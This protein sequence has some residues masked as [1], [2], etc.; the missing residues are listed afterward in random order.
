MKDVT[1]SSNISRINLHTW[2]LSVK[3]AT[4]SSTFAP[5]AEVKNVYDVPLLLLRPAYK[6]NF[7]LIYFFHVFLKKTNLFF[8]YDARLESKDMRK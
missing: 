1:Q 8:Q 5:F 2:L 4:S 6:K 7:R 3:I